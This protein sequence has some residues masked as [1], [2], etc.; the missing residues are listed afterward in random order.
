MATGSSEA[1]STVYSSTWHS[2]CTDRQQQQQQ[3]SV[4][5]SRLMC[6]D[7]VKTDG[8]EKRWQHVV[9]HG[10]TWQHL[11]EMLLLLLAVT[12]HARTCSPMCCRMVSARCLR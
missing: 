1:P 9:L 10:T 8:H 5:Y 2:R 11:L 12:T 7:K 6:R 3:A 4:Y